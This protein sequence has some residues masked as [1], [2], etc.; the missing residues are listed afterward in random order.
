M[1]SQ[2][3]RITTA[4]ERAL[5]GA[6]VITAN[7]RAARRLRLETERRV[8]QEKTVCETPDIVP[9][10]AWVSRTWTD[11]LLAGVVNQALVKRNVAAALWRET[12]AESA[13]GR[14]LLS[15]AA[16]AELAGRAWQLIFDYKLPR[17]RA[18][19]AGTSESKA[20]YGWAEAFEA[21]CEREG[22]I[23]SARALKTIIDR[24]GRLPK[25][26]KEI[27]VFGFDRFA[28][29]QEGLWAALRGAGCHVE[30]LAPE[31]MT[32]T[33]HAHVVACEDTAEEIRTAA[34]WARKKLEENPAARVGV[35]VPGLEGLRGTIATIF[36]DVL[37]PE[38][39]LLT[40]ES[41]A[42]AFEISLGRPL[43]EH[44]MV[45]AALRLLRLAAGTVRADEFS[46]LL[47]SPYVSAGR[48]EA[49]SRAQLD[50][51][52]RQR[53]KL[54][55]VVTLGGALAFEGSYGL[56]PEFW[57]MLRKMRAEAP[58]ST[59]RFT[60]TQWVERVR[61]MLRAAGWR[62]ESDGEFALNSE[63]FQAGEK[64]DEVL[65]DFCA[66]DQVLPP[67]SMAELLRELESAAAEATFAAEN[68]AAPVQ[69]VGPIAASGECFD[70]TWICGLSD[71]AWPQRGHPNPFIPFVV[72]KEAGLPHSSPETNL[73]DAELITARLLQSSDTCVL[74]WAEREEDREL[75]PSPLLRRFATMHRE[76]IEVAETVGWG[77]RPRKADLEEIVDERAPAV[78]DEELRTHG[79]FVLQWQSACPFRSFAQ[80]RL[81]ADQLRDTPMGISAI[82]RGNVTELA[83]QYV[84]EHLR[85]HQ[86][87]VGGLPQAEV[88]RA[89]EESI[90]RAIA[91]RFPKG[92]E[93]WL[94][95]HREIERERLN[96]LVREWLEVEKERHPFHNIQAQV[97]EETLQIAGL[98]IRAQIDRVE[99]TVDGDYVVIDYKTGAKHSEKLWETPRP[100]DPQLPI[101]AVAQMSKGHEIA[102][103]AFA[104]VRAGACGFKGIAAR[105]DI[106]G[107]TRNSEAFA[108]TIATWQPELERLATNLLAGDAEVD[109]KNLPGTTNSSCEYCHLESLCRV[110][111]VV[112]PAD[113]DDEEESDDE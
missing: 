106:F 2:Q 21:R 82:E 19:F 89:I 4:L 68:E 53:Q 102:G 111:E 50:F 109:P 73:R 28:P 39:R 78:K 24:A 20:F 94:V 7:T 104:K 110:A 18:L 38:G 77:K 44:P 63:E 69:I 40:E 86:N 112:A 15:H 59:E 113:E 25:L 6:T 88:E 13:A 45:R 3:T 54:R 51:I 33:E 103:V 31:E 107:R 83:L 32:P 76:S 98:T 17:N 85:T 100:Q 30:L 57:K 1:G 9:L 22:W 87:L 58:K 65:T 56:A 23:D 92:E 66:L 84:W 5:A 43:A 29:A 81:G 61:T 80:A 72:Q 64:W 34:G 96:K 16:A 108:A 101:Y 46:A 27:V 91:D 95:K 71:D 74:S 52:L 55:A 93:A 37:H 11:A 47:R 36:E 97:K 90:D 8:F 62:G 41:G 35:I 70:A 42:K 12:V 99:Q 49:S 79:T 26:P 75:R 14:Q 48:S 67:R 105:K 10:E 60:H